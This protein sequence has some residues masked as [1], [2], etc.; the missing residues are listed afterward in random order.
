MEKQ[1]QQFIK[2]PIE[3]KYKYAFSPDTFDPNAFLG[4]GQFGSVFKGFAITEEQ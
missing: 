1:Q 3:G 4:K 2:I